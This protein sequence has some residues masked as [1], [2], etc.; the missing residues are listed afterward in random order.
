MQETV[1]KFEGL[2]NVNLIVDAIY[3]GGNK[4][5]VG[6]D[7][8]SK[9]MRCENQGGFRKLGNAESF[10]LKYVILYSTLEDNDWRDEIDIYKGHFI[11]YGDN[12]KPGTLL[13]ETRKKGNEILRKC[14]DKL[15]LGD[16]S[17]IP[18][19]FIF[20]KSVDGRD[21][22]FRGL[23][24]PGAEGVSQSEDLVAV[25]KVKN[26]NRFQNYKALFTILDINEIKRSWLDD[27]LI[28]NKFSNN[29]PVEYSEWISSGIYR[30]LIA[31]KTIE[32]RT[33]IQQ[34]PDNDY[35]TD[36]INIVYNY[37]KVKPTEFEKCA[38]KLVELMDG[39]VLDWDVTRPWLDG[40]RDVLGKYVIGTH[41][42]NI[43]VE[44]A[45][46]AKCFE[47]NS[48]VGVKHTSRLISRIRNRQFGVLVTTSYVANQAYR[49]I[50]EDRH[51]I[52][53]LCS[54]DI[55]NI[56]KKKVG[57]TYEEIINWLQVN[58]PIK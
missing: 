35:D 18:P 23:A 36:I 24:V 4:G 51:P 13:H 42:D 46:E 20:T 44:Y 22:K 41:E 47:L 55:V 9:L 34:L 37:F 31:D 40:G 3:K 17:D 45:I 16:R 6:D 8:L 2:E 21:V 10:Q 28:G 58:F 27:L 54:K 38:A 19:F 52:I 1:F 50:R 33:K 11:Y 12:K 5:N 57:N 25:W 48:S 32:Y 14:Y 53:I 30:P 15:H 29:C 43:I 7:P 49:E 39:N 56:L 26:G